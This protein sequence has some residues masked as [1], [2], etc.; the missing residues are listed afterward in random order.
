MA[1][2][3]QKGDAQL[4]Q[5]IRKARNFRAFQYPLGE[6]NLAKDAANIGIHRLL[7]EILPEIV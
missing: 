7:P 6:S 5:G 2:N 1:T 3:R 4:D